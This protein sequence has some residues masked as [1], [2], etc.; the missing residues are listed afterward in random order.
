MNDNTGSAGR[1]PEDNPD[2]VL[3][4]AS[5]DAPGIK[6]L[7]LA[8]DTY[9]ML[10]TGDQTAG[11]YCLID[12]Y[13]PPGGGP[14]PHRHN[15][16]EMFTILEG[17]VDFTFRGKT[18]AVSAG[19]TV[20]IPANAPHFFRNNSGQPIRMLCMCSPAGQD[21]YF[22]RVGDLVDTRTALPPQLTDEE[23]VERREQAIRL[24]PEYQTEMMVN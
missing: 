3:T 24:A 2:R 18:L 12:M 22:M 16:E 9:A 6:Y 10:I 19:S 7:S 8:G 14:P 21:E 13:V 1:L 11:R 23:I 20:N 17:E 15:F 5:A 4:V